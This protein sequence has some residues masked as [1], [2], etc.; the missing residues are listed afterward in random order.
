MSEMGVFGMQMYTKKFINALMCSHDTN[1]LICHLS[2]NDLDGFGCTILSKTY[3]QLFDVNRIIA[4]NTGSM[5]K[6]GNFKYGF[7]D[8]MDDV[9]LDAF[10]KCYDRTMFIIS[11]IG[12]IDVKDLHKIITDAAN[13]MDYQ[14]EIDELIE[15][16]PVFIIDH[17]KSKYEGYPSGYSD[18][19]VCVNFDVGG[20]TFVQYKNIYYWINHNMSATKMMWTLLKNLPD[21]AYMTTAKS[22]KSYYPRWIAKF[23][24]YVSDYDTG[25]F[26]NWR[27]P[28]GYE[29]LPMHEAL[30]NISRQNILNILMRRMNA[31]FKPYVDQFSDEYDLD[32]PVDYYTKFSDSIFSKVMVDALL[33][34]K[35]TFMGNNINFNHLVRCLV[36]PELAIMNE[37]YLSWLERGNTFTTHEKINM[38]TGAGTYI[39]LSTLKDGTKIHFLHDGPGQGPYNYSVYAKQYLEDFPDVDM[40]MREDFEN[41]PHTI[42]LRSYMKEDGTPRADCYALAAANGGGGH[43]C[44]AGFQARTEHE[45]QTQL[46][47]KALDN[48]E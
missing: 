38:T 18:D 16:F 10:D 28:Q 33:N 30:K 15:D 48:K 2:H 36:M 43:V 25:N 42:N 21:E 26:G 5:V 12:S 41:T 17:H 37:H 1:D 24:Q 11:D 23:A 46:N 8:V 20:S 45:I 4:R 27:L 47:Q 31:I 40:I 14:E 44:A 32:M 7:Y 39:D 13:A 22:N 35:I 19:G 9:A 29:S 34:R 6:D 3:E